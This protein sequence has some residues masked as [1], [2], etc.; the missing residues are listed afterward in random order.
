M[1]KKIL[2]VGYTTVFALCLQGCDTFFPSWDT[3][4]M[5]DKG[6]PKACA[7]TIMFAKDPYPLSLRGGFVI[8]GTSRQIGLSENVEI[9]L[10]QGDPAHPKKLTVKNEQID[11]LNKEPSI[12]ITL[13]EQDLVDFNAGAA[14][15]TLTLTPYEGATPQIQ[16]VSLQLN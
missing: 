7:V 13:F 10:S 1:K 5:C 14:T 4:T 9:I 6:H 3:A 8:A 12:K 11:V 15:L 2:F 16:T